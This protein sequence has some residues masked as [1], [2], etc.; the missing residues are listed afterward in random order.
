MKK[1]KYEDLD[2]QQKEAYNALKTDKEKEDFLN[3]I[4]ITREGLEN[5]DNNTDESNNNSGT[6]NATNSTDKDGDIDSIIDK[7]PEL[8]EEEL[9]KK[10]NNAK[11]HENKQ[12]EKEQEQP[13]K[14]TG[15]SFW[16]FIGGIVVV[17]AFVVV[18]LKWLG[19]IGDSDTPTAETVTATAESTADTISETEQ[20]TATPI[21]S[22]EEL[23]NG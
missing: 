8:N 21:S 9:K 3:D 15:G 22:Y 20:Q 17:G 7:E 4:A 10:E 5:N 19:F 12:K 14:D 16:G 11:Y 13:D 18:V 2:K 6:N 23:T 1:V